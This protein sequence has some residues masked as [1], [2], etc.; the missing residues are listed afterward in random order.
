MIPSMATTS[1]TPAG[2][3]FSILG[4]AIAVV[5]GF[6]P[7]VMATTGLGG[8]F[9][10][11]AFQFGAHESFSVDGVVLMV[12]GTI[13]VIIGIVRLTNSAMP[14]FLQRS[15]IVLGIVVALVPLNRLPA[16]NSS[17]HNIQNACSGAC[18]ASIGY[19]VYTAFVG[20][21]LMLI[22]GFVLRARSSHE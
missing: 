5:S 22:G 12:L 3:W 2:A 15:P 1:T 17:V 8:G 9:T 11:N 18:T 13:A 4:G 14:R 10:R 16:I 6:L 20:A 21:L 7:W 19:G